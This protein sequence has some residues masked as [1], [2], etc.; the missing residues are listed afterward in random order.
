MP[1]SKGTSREAVSKN[2]RK[3]R[4]EGYPQEQA[5][6]IALDVQRRAKQEKRNAKNR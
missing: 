3:L 6:A 1:L 5:V 4:E 2:I